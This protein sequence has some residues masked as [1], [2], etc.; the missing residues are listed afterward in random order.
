M[1]EPHLIILSCEPHTSGI[2]AVSICHITVNIGHEILCNTWK[3]LLWHHTD[4]TI[5][6]AYAIK[7]TY[8]TFTHPDALYAHKH[9]T[10]SYCC[11]SGPHVK[12]WSYKTWHKIR[13]FVLLYVYWQNFMPMFLFFFLSEALMLKCLTKI[14]LCKLLCWKVG[15]LAY[16]KGKANC[17]N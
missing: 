15:K 12:S 5:N 6:F 14:P 2:R 16:H 10:C 4:T 9:C 11:C 3:I 17:F 7:H 8:E 1:S 13:V